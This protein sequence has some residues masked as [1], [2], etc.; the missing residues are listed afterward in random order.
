MWSGDGVRS[1]AFRTLVAASPLRHADKEALVWSEAFDRFQVLPLRRI[2]PGDIGQK[3][4][5]QVRDVFAQRQLTVDLDIV[6]DGVL[7]ILIGNT[8][9]AYFEFCRVFLGPP[10]L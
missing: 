8:L 7:R 3:R 2:L 6:H 10:V 9:G 4:S 1:L 5:T